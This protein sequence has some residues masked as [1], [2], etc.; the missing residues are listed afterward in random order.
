MQ[1]EMGPALAGVFMIFW[2]FISKLCTTEPIVYEEQYLHPG[3]IIQIR[4]YLS[5]GK[6]ATIS[7]FLAYNKYSKEL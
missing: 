4:K 2:I 7:D 5:R 6:D 1:V 3:T